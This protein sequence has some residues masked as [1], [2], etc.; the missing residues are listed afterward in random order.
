MTDPGATEPLVLARADHNLSRKNIDQ[1]AI[2]VLYRLH[3]AGFR[4]CLVGGSVRDLLLGRRPK[5]FDVATS[6]RP[7]EVR[8]LFRNSRII[9]RR[10]RLAHIY[11]RDGIVEVSTFRRDPDPEAQA[12]APGELLITNDNVFGTPREDAFRRDFGINALFYDIADYSVIDYVGGIE[13]LERRTI[14]V[15]GDPDLRFREDPVRMT[16][17]CE[18][19]ARLDFTI[20]A[21]TQDGIRRHAAEILKAAPARLTEEIGQLLRCGHSGSAMQWMLELGMLDIALPE[22]EAFLDTRRLGLGDFTCTLSLLD[23]RV[24]RG[25]P[26]S[27]I[28][29]YSSLLLPTV[30]VRCGERCREGRDPLSVGGARELIADAIGPFFRRFTLSRHKAEQVVQTILGFK[31]MRGRRWKTAERIK[32]SQRGFFEDALWLYEIAVAAKGEGDDELRR[33]RRVAHSRPPTETS[34]PRDRPR[35][36]GRRRGRGGRGRRRARR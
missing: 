8:K 9:G 29:L 2:K 21:A 10:F 3:Q 30:L 32:F 11:F 36:R 20:E 31:Q 25:R 15:I 26:L 5:D 17:A 28:G 7:G 22:V 1:G 6:A 4:A 33:W 23:R 35:R 34:A 27:E 18:L 24:E 14:R 12:S 13:D 16:R 19:A